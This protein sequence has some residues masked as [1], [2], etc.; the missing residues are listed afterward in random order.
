MHKKRY[1]VVTRDVMIVAWLAA[2]ILPNEILVH[3]Q[4][5]VNDAKILTI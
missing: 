5:Y 2:T 4:K 1:E 3:A